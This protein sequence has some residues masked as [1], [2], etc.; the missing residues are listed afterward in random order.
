MVRLRGPSRGVVGGLCLGIIFVLLGEMLMFFHMHSRGPVFQ[1]DELRKAAT[2]KIEADAESHAAAE[3][4]KDI[5]REMGS[6]EPNTDLQSLA[7]DLKPA[8]LALKSA[9]AKAEAADRVVLEMEEALKVSEHDAFILPWQPTPTPHDFVKDVEAELSQKAPLPHV[10]VQRKSSNAQTE[11][12]AERGRLDKEIRGLQAKLDAK[13]S[14]GVADAEKERSKAAAEV[15]DLRGELR[16]HIKVDRAAELQQAFKQ[17]DIDGDSTIGFDELLAL[18]KEHHKNQGKGEWTPWHNGQLLAKITTDFGRSGNIKMNEFV[19]YFTKS[20]PRNDEKFRAEMQSFAQAAKNAANHVV[21]VHRE[22]DATRKRHMGPIGVQ[23]NP[24][25]L[26]IHES[27]SEVV[28][29]AGL[30]VPMAGDAHLTAVSDAIAGDVID[31]S[32]VMI[33]T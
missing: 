31:A 30:G 14:A 25:S 32:L 12:D 24:E 7:A 22:G 18:G 3:K 20:L 27:H 28:I 23:L 6:G 2:A 8:Q 10:R 15:N 19:A 26:Q 16:E 13:K 4:M 33:S 17:F 29:K 21:H 1:Q 9:T 5:F 11:A